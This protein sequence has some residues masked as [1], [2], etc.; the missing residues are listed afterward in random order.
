M[1]KRHMR[2]AHKGGDA[3]KARQIK[4]RYGAEKVI[5]LLLASCLPHQSRST[6]QS[7]A[8]GARIN[9]A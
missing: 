6:R 1:V 2:Q 3:R 9:S 8:K 4:A 7:K 5:H